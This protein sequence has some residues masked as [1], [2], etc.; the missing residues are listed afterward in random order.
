MAVVMVTIRDPVEVILDRRWVVAQVSL[1]GEEAVVMEEA[2]TV[3]I[4]V[5]IS[6]NREP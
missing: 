1:T 6:T 3:A 4:N 2:A 5:F